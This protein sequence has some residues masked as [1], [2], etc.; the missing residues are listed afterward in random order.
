MRKTLIILGTLLVAILLVLGACAKP[1][2]LPAAFE[3]TTMNV[4]P[5]EVTAGETANI[6]AEVRNT[7]GSEG[8]YT[9]VLTVDGA[10]VET[11]GVTLAAGISKTVTFSLVKDKPGTYQVSIGG[12]ISSL[13]VKQKLVV[14]EVELKYDD[15]N[16]RDCL[17]AE[18]P[19]LSG[20]LVDFTPLTTPFTIKKI[21]IAG[22]LA[23][24]TYT[25]GLEGK[26][27]DAQ[28]WDKDLKVLYSTTYPY[29][30]FTTYPS[31]TWVELE[32][33]D[34]EVSNKFYVHIYTASPRFGLHIGADDS[35]VNEHS[36]ATLRTE[37]G[38]DIVLAQWPY[39][40]SLWFGDKSKV[41]WMIRVVG[42]AM[43][44]PD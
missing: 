18:V 29:T 16:A 44:P 11:I 10:T 8:T 19:F 36:E 43:L 12:L 41:N 42:T 1:A 35:I 33:P 30:K 39:D 5:P 15:G 22:C 34:I 28:I 37:G 32:I 21:R 4:T 40:A 31:V 14:K 38:T 2:P 13:T 17:S 9:A 26:T 24:G 27:F 25:K 23:G 3:V 6:T 7:G 20:H